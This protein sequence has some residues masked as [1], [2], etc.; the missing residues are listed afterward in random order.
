MLTKTNPITDIRDVDFARNA[1]F[2]MKERGMT[3]Y[4]VF[5]GIASPSA[6]ARIDDKSGHLVFR[7]G[8]FWIVVRQDSGK[9]A[10]VIAVAPRGELP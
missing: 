10:T 9:H 8:Q 3:E 5:R 7:V 2:R 1:L 4:D 6:E